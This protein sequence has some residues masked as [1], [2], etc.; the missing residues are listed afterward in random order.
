MLKFGVSGV[1]DSGQFEVTV[2]LVGSKI[3][4]HWMEEG[5]ETGSW[6]DAG[7]EVHL[8]HNFAQGWFDTDWDW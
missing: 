1:L 5:T 7:D 4:S 2:G 6:T 3:Q 8:C